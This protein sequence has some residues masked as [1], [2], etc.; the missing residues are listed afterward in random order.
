MTPLS[1]ADS[2][3]LATGLAE[4]DDLLGRRGIVHDL[5]GVPGDGDVGEAHDLDGHGRPGA[6]EHLAVLV[7][8]GPDLAH[9]QARD[10]GLA[11]FERALLDD[12]R[13]EGA[14]LAVEAGLEDDALGRDLADWP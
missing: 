3:F 7:E 6:L 9:G 8:H 5:E 4:L 13:G 2:G 10:E 14:F 11:L 1:R 12:D